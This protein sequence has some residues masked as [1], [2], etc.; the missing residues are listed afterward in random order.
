MLSDLH[1]NDVPLVKLEISMSVSLTGARLAPRI[2]SVYSQGSGMPPHFDGLIVITFC[3]QYFQPNGIK[4]DRPGSRKPEIIR[5]L[6]Y[7]IDCVRGQVG[8]SRRGQP[9]TF[10][11]LRPTAT[12]AT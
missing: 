11:I 10:V 12:V 9:Q 6:G 8:L 7:T 1:P 2:L 5:L 4:R 3:S